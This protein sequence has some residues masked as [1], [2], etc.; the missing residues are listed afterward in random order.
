MLSAEEI[1][2][3][4][5]A[6]MNI[7]REKYGVEKL[8]LFGSLSR[9]EA[10]PDSDVDILVEFTQPL[11]FVSFLKLEKELENLLGRRVD[12]VTRKALKKHIGAN[13]LNEIKYVQ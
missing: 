7:L 3:T 8:G 6:Q 11:G 12:L 5:Q 2:S 9:G 1:Q 10:R 4:L 13:I